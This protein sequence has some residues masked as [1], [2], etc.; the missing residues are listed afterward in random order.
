MNQREIYRKLS[1]SVS[2]LALEH[3]Y[4]STQD[5]VEFNYV[6]KKLSAYRKAYKALDL[7]KILPISTNLRSVLKPIISSKEEEKGFNF[8]EGRKIENAAE[9]LL[10]SVKGILSLLEAQIVDTVEE[11]T[12]DVKFIKIDDL[13]ELEKVAGLLKRSFA[14]PAYELDGKITVENLEKGSIWIILGVISASSILMKM[15]ANLIWAAVVVNNRYEETKITQE[16]V[17]TIKLKNDL[18]EAIVEHQKQHLDSFKESEATAIA[19]EFIPNPTP[20][21]IQQLKMSIESISLLIDKGAQFYPSIK[22][23]EEVKQLFPDFNIKKLIE[24]K[25]KLLDEGDTTES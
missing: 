17:R 2:N 19:N 24:S 9:T 4:F 6:F 20:E 8:S 15:C 21:K 3:Q 23:P 16:H 10:E 18:I 25:T 13:D 12:I 22:A 11:N 14:I 7:N 5:P 1:E